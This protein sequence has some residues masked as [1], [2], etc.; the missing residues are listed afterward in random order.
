M[1]RANI[2]CSIKS[3]GRDANANKTNQALELG[4]KI[5]LRDQQDQQANETND[6]RN[7]C[8]SMK[9]MMFYL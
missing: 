9:S 7:E 8:R 5:E 6:T 2:E 4:E 3:T 1:T